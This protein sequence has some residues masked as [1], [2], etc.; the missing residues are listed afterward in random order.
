MG[1]RTIRVV[2]PCRDTPGLP[3]SQEHAAWL[4]RVRQAFAGQGWR[5]PSQGPATNAD[6]DALCLESDGGPMPRST[7]EAT[8]RQA[9]I[10]PLYWH[11]DVDDTA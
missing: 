5:A 1:L 2:Y 7:L 8:L 9:G 10:S 11:G 4:G 3:S 6:E